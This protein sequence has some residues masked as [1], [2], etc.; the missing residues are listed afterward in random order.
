MVFGLVFTDYDGSSDQTKEPALVKQDL[1][2]AVPSM[3]PIRIGP[4]S[5]PETAYANP[6][7]GPFLLSIR[8]RE[9]KIEQL[10][11]ARTESQRKEL[12][13]LHPLQDTVVGIPNIFLATFLHSMVLTNIGN[14]SAI[15]MKVGNE[16][17]HDGDVVTDVRLL[18][19][20]LITYPDTFHMGSIRGRRTV[21]SVC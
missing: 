21:F 2:Q 1:E 9:A 18:R 4:L 20:G 5:N 19:N 10:I 12:T 11:I 15:A 7:G 14:P 8:T 16:K 17:G 3:V 6:G 13:T